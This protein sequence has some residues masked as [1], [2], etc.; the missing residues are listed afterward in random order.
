MKY[1]RE[2]LFKKIDKEQNPAYRYINIPAWY[3]AF[4][5]NALS[6]VKD[7]QNRSS[8]NY[9]ENCKIL[10]DVG[11][12]LIRVVNQDFSVEGSKRF[13]DEQVKTIGDYK[14]KNN[15]KI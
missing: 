7:Q 3:V 10:D 1:I 9:E 13:G 2:L 6:R 5:Y 15:G 4:I 12:L 11:N 8:K 14:M